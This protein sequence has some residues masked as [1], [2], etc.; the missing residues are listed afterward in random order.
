MDIIGYELVATATANSRTTPPSRPPLMDANDPLDY[1][2][3]AMRLAHD[4]VVEIVVARGAVR[5]RKRG[6]K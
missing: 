6:K 1:S 5:V 4:R 3:S 2:P